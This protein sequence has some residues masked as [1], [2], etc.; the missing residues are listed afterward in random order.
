MDFPLEK[1]DFCHIG[2]QK[3]YEPL[4]FERDLSSAAHISGPCLSHLSQR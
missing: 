3:G 2:L 1:S 4:L